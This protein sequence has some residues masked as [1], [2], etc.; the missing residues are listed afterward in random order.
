MYEVSFAKLSDRHYKQEAWPAVELIADLVDRDHVFCLL[1]KVRLTMHGGN[2]ASSPDASVSCN[3]P[4]LTPAAGAAFTYMAAPVVFQEL[5]YRHL[6][7]RCKPDLSQRCDSFD[8]YCELFG[9]IL[10]GK[11][12][13]QLPNAWL[14]DMVDEFIYQFQSFCQYRGKVSMMSP[15]ELELLKGCDKVRHPRPT[16]Q[17]T[18]PTGQATG[19]TIM[20]VLGGLNAAAAA[21]AWARQWWRQQQEAAVEEEQQ[22][23][24]RFMHA[25]L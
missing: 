20:Q 7:A 6:Y 24:Q 25:P 8:N 12:N 16:G 21:A 22:L 19:S 10:H 1:Y 2:G 5:Y 3:F 17:A 9:V 11:L 15:Q 14:W 23:R 13:M 18:R 4:R